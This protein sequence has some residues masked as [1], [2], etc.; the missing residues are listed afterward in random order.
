MTRSPARAARTAASAVLAFLIAG[1]GDSPVASPAAP[2][3]PDLST[4]YSGSLIQCPTDQTLTA[5][6]LIGILG[7]VIQL[8]GTTITIPVGAL[9]TPST[10][11]VTIPASDH[12]EVQLQVG[13]HLHFE[14]LE[15]VV[16]S[17]S[18]AR[19]DPAEVEG[20]GLGVW[21][22]DENDNLLEYHGGIQDPITRRITAITTH[23]SDYA[24]GANRSEP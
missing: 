24:V 19:C 9:L 5:S 14:F 11:R 10:V 1:C 6:G 12:L 4:S 15:P 21:Y 17:I 3:G 2:T 23:F 8:G 18:Y 22:I 20:K 16:M 7:G 13:D